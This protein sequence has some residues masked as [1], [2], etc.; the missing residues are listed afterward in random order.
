MNEECE[1]QVKRQSEVHAGIADVKEIIDQLAETFDDLNEQ[2]LR[3]DLKINQAT[4]EKLRL[5]LD[6]QKYKK[7]GK[8]PK[9]KSSQNSNQQTP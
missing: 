2:I 6:L 9:A 3:V 7:L 4:N 1:S 8:Q 5:E